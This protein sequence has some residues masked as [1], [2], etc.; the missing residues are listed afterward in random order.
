MQ[1]KTGEKMDTLRKKQLK[2]KH[3]TGNSF[4]SSVIKYSL[5]MGNN[6]HRGL[7]E[8]REIEELGKESASP[9][10]INCLA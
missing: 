7:A 2:S 10:V 5:S 4:I 6:H 9:Y 8:D 1:V 3:A